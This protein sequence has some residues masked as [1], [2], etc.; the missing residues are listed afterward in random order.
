MNME[1]TSI[2]FRTVR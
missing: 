2:F 1:I